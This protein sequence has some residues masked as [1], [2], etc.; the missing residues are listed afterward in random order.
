MEIIFIPEWNTFFITE[1]C[2]WVSITLGYRFSSI[3]PKLT[4]YC[5]CFCTLKAQCPT[6]VGHQLYNNWYLLFQLKNKIRGCRVGK[7]CKWNFTCIITP[8]IWIFS[9]DKLSIVATPDTLKLM[10]FKPKTIKLV[11]EEDTFL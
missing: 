6:F 11:R 1:F 8:N 3:L 4:H 7:I 2:Q 9:T 10:L 5:I